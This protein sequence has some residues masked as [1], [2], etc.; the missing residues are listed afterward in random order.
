MSDL[1]AAWVVFICVVAVGPW[2]VWWWLMDIR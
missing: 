1:Q 2:V